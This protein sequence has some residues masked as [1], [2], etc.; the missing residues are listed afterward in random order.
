[1]NDDSTEK[2]SRGAA[3]AAPD[4]PANQPKKIP[5]EAI[6]TLEKGSAEAIK[7]KQGIFV[8]MAIADE[9]RREEEKARL[10]K[11]ARQR[12]IYGALGVLL[13]LLAAAALII[14]LRP[15][16]DT[17][18]V[19]NAGSAALKFG[20]AY[21]QID[22]TG[23]SKREFVQ[24]LHAELSLSVPEGIVKTIY[25]TEASGSG[26][27]RITIGRFFEIL[28]A[29]P[30]ES[31]AGRTLERDFLVNA[32]G[33]GGTQTLFILARASSGTNALKDMADWEPTMA[34]DMADLF[35]ISATL[36][37]NRGIFGKPFEDRY[38]D[39]ILMRVLENN[40]GA[41]LLSYTL[42]NDQT[43]IIASEP[44]SISRIIG[45]LYA[46]AIRN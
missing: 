45:W 20:T 35:G 26:Q 27:Q 4:M 7:G 14:A 36:E 46:P 22:A 6:R 9:K 13:V 34:S 38:V 29:T 43:L 33:G 39:N 5:E 23:L 11:L 41:S 10:E 19:R 1:M 2:T 31:L 12:V 28:E 24:D 17:G 32:I 21:A 18:S 40:S 37:E 30:P 16:G 44:E 15:G 3:N 25:V 42:L 8:K